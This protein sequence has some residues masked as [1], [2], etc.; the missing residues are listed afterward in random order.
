MNAALA[1]APTSVIVRRTIAAAPEEIFDAWLDPE[2]L[3]IW[4]RPGSINHTHAKVDA[5]VGGRY[6]IF[7]QSDTADYPHSGEYR[8]IDRPRRL[9][10]TWQSS[11]TQGQE[12]LVTVD[13]LPVDQRTE[14]VVTHERLP[15]AARES[16][17]NGWT[18]GIQRL[19]QF[20]SGRTH[21]G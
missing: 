1:P 14:V 13:F 5:R 19:D 18:S 2:A 10:F 17:T 6:E 20:I 21:H 12:T 11:G 16:H 4:M 9:V 15:E 7:M 3:G 8:V